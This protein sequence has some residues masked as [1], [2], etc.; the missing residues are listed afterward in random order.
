MKLLIW[1]VLY[2]SIVVTYNA[3][4]AR[5]HS[6]AIIYFAPPLLI[7]SHNPSSVHESVVEQMNVVYDDEVLYNLGVMTMAYAAGRF[8]SRPVLIK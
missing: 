5:Y 7:S 4:L 8:A 6:T 3:I 1:L 2:V